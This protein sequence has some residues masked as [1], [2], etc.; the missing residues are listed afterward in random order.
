MFFFNPMYANPTYILYMLP[1]LLLGFWAQTRLRGTF[2]RFAKVATS[3]GVNGQTAAQVL[4]RQEGLHIAVK[5]TSGMLSDFY[6]PADKSINLSQTSGQNSIASVA[7]V[8]HELGHAVQDMQGYGPMALRRAI[9]P[10]VSASVW[11][12][13]GLFLVGYFLSNPTFLWA[14]IFFFAMAAIFAVVTLPVEFDASHRGLAMLQQSGILSAAE[15]PGAKQVLDAAA[16]TYVA[17][18]AQSVMTLLYYLTL[19]G[20]RRR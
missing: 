14:G 6:N 4:M 11:L 2:S 8:A 10:A 17:A 15:I 13:P 1:A 19:L 20:G 9:V 7:V 3:S 16:L 5:G 12:G 18:A